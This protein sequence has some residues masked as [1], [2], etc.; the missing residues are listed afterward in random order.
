MFLIG[1]FEGLNVIMYLILLSSSFFLGF[2]RV[3]LSTIRILDTA[4]QRV[5]SGYF[6]V[7]NVFMMD[8]ASEMKS[9]FFVQILLALTNSPYGI[10][11]FWQGCISCDRITPTNTVTS[12]DNVTLKIRGNFNCQSY[13]CIY[14][15]TCNCCKKKYVGESSQ[16][17][18]L[19][20]RG[21]E[22]HIRYYMKHSNNP[23]AQHYGINK[24]TEKEYT[25]EI[26]DQE[27]DKNKRN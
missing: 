25:V 1:G 2:S 20:L 24:L 11:S 22:S 4:A 15:L 21:H 14:C 9:S 3:S 17:V 23:V 8:L 26:L 27:K 5:V 10:V 6:L 7:L 13:N 16:T 18:N 12:S 19:R